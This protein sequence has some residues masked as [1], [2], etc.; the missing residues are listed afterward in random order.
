M[1][2]PSA[3]RRAE[4]QSSWKGW[5]MHDQAETPR[6]PRIQ[7]M[8][9]LQRDQELL[10]ILL[11]DVSLSQSK[12]GICIDRYTTPVDNGDDVKRMPSTIR[13][14]H[15]FGVIHIGDED[16]VMMMHRNLAFGKARE[17]RLLLVAFKGGVETYCF[18]KA[19]CF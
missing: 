18:G 8:H 7:C 15:H 13:I 1:D 6:T 12:E 4:G 2:I 3:T 11:D 10:S 16:D 19:T 9:A 14:Y 17:T 5:E